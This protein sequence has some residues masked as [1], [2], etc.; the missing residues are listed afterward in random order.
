MNDYDDLITQSLQPEPAQAARIGFAAAIDTNPEAYAEARRVA[1]RTGVPVDTAFNLPQEM[2]RQDRMGSMDFDRLAAMSPAT[3]AILADV[4]QAKIAHDNVDSFSGIEGVLTALGGA[5][6]YTVSAPGAARG[7]FA[8][9]V[10]RAGSAGLSGL[11]SDSAW[12]VGL[13]QAP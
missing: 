1:K 7:G 11:Q 2:K 13:A 9:D 6:K 12:V 10:G 3:A 8:S 4:D 5:A